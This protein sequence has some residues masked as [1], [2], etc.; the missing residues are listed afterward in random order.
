M[1]RVTGVVAV[2]VLASAFLLTTPAEAEAGWCCHRRENVR[3]YPVSFC[4]PGYVMMHCSY[5]YWA[6]GC[7][8]NMDCACRPITDLGKRCYRAECST[9]TPTPKRRLFRR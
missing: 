2:C 8:P 6:Y 9:P 7:F 4:P 5:G 1:N 3:S